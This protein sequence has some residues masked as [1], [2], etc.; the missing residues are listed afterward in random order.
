MAST[1]EQFRKMDLYKPP[2]LAESI[3][4]ASALNHLGA[5]ELTR[6]LAMATL[7]TVLKYSEDQEKAS[8][9]AFI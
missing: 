3:V 2:G 6:D 4:W 1:V 8:E 7:G 5:E 9:V